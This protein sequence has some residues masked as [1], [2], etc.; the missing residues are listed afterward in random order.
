MKNY[1]SD[2]SALQSPHF[3]MLMSFYF[4]TM[5]KKSIAKQAFFPFQ[6]EI[7]ITH[8]HALTV[9]WWSR[10]KIGTSMN[11]YQCHDASLSLER[12]SILWEFYIN[13]IAPKFLKR[14]KLNISNCRKRNHHSITLF[15]LGIWFWTIWRGQIIHEQKYDW[16]PFAMINKQRF[17]FNDNRNKLQPAAS[18]Y[19]EG[20]N[21]KGLVVKMVD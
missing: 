3:C 17:S 21:L 16:T 14:H 6:L 19:S 18:A 5:S 9:T 4:L 8:F 10:H 2:F 11:Y 15:S 13:P 20:G 7:L 12:D 1:L